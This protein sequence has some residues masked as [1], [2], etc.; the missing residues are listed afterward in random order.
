MGRTSMD[1]LEYRKISCPYYTNQTTIP[2][3]PFHSPVNV[4]TELSWLFMHREKPTY[5]QISNALYTYKI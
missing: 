3:H 5:L 4:P 2:Y 1:N